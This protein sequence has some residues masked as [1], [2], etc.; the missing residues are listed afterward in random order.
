[1]FPRTSFNANV[2]AD[3]CADGSHD[4]LRLASLWSRIQIL[5]HE[6]EIRDKDAK[7]AALHMVCP[8]PLN[9]TLQSPIIIWT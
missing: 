7:Y 6:D 1:M 2:Q 4:G 9:P 3:A 5:D 8:L